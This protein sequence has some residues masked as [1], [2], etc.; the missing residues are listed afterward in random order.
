MPRGTKSYLHAS[1]KKARRN[2]D[3]EILDEI[4][5]SLN[6]ERLSFVRE[7]SITLSTF[8]TRNK[9]HIPDFKFKTGK[10]TPILEEDSNKHHGDFPY[11]NESTKKRNVDHLRSGFPL[12]LLSRDLARQLKLPLGPLAVYLYYHSIAIFE[13]YSDLY[14]EVNQK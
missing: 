6:N 5:R 3:A 10:L 8:T 14:G 12:S 4:Q 9:T 13:A 11:Q 2:A 1:N 7:E